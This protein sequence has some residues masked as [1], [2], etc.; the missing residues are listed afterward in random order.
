MW[1]LFQGGCSWAP[2][3]Y[4]D[5]SVEPVLDRGKF[6]GWNRPSTVMLSPCCRRHTY[7]VYQMHARHSPWWTHLV[8]TT[9]FGPF[10]H[11]GFP[12]NLVFCFYMVQYSMSQ[13]YMLIQDREILKY[14]ETK[15]VATLA[16]IFNG[17]CGFSSQAWESYRESWLH[18]DKGGRHNLTHKTLRAMSGQ[19]LFLLPFHHNLL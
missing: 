12:Q 1:K 3:S 14:W 9:N 6:T 2:H 19:L 10:Y 7:N 18:A 4:N 8:C 15:H 13:C 16:A 11:S 5:H 17:C